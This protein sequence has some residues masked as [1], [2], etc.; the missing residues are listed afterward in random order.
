MI[1]APAGADLAQ[2]D[3]DYL[4]VDG[5]LRTL[6]DAR[7]LRTG[8]EVGL[9]DLLLERPCARSEAERMLGLDAAGAGL[10]AQLL[11][12]NGVV[13][14]WD[15][16]LRLD[17]RFRGALRYRDLLEAKL[18]FAGFTINDFA[19]LF[20]TLIRDPR[21]FAGQ[22]RLFEL[23]DYRRCL[24]FT[25]ENYERTRGWMRLTSALTRY[26]SRACMQLHDFSRFR[27]MLD[28][29]GNSGEFVLQVLR[30]H[31]DLEGTVFDLPLV[32]E[33]GMEHV[34]TEPEHERIAFFKGDI[35][36]DVLPRGYD[37]IAFKS[38]L[39]DWPV[40]EASRFVAKAARALEPGGTLLIFER[41]PLSF[42][43]V[44][45]FSMLPILL[46]FRSYRVPDGYEK[47]LAALGFEAIE[48]R[49]IV[50]DTPFFLV[51][52]RKPERS[53]PPAAR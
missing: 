19:D 33:I 36:N 53:A 28:V 52:A 6:V 5:Y 12:A 47:Q 29:G 27:R 20:T 50:L 3:L 25:A 35:R 39:H 21:G 51:T 37:L 38:M 30:R 32:C 34:L 13:T 1:A 8:F 46:F 18:D 22:A 45:P 4:C 31:R 40:E 23:F 44:P 10:L 16:V 7:V 43:G 24:D 14:E 11:A 9:I 41:G 2:G 17:E 26:E 48:R 15:G 49:E 42:D